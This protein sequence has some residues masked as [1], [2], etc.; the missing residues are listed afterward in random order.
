M[1]IVEVDDRQRGKHLS[2]IGVLGRNN[3]AQE[4]AIGSPF[5]E[6]VPPI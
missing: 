2:V 5:V 4:M 1:L 3:N 6:P